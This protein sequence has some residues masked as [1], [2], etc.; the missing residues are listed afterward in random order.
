MTNT[1]IQLQSETAKAF[2][3]EDFKSLLGFKTNHFRSYVEAPHHMLYNENATRG[4][5]PYSIFLHGEIDG[6]PQWGLK[7]PMYVKI[8]I[9]I[10]VLRELR[11]EISFG[12]DD[13]VTSWVAPPDGLLEWDR[14][15]RYSTRTAVNCSYQAK[16]GIKSNNVNFGVGFSYQPNAT[17]DYRI[18]N[19]ITF[20]GEYR[21]LLQLQCE[22][23]FNKPHDF[24]AQVCLLLNNKMANE[25]IT[26]KYIDHEWYAIKAF[27]VRTIYK[28][29][30]YHNRVHDHILGNGGEDDYPELLL[31]PGNINIQQPHR[32]VEATQEEPSQPPV[33]ARPGRYVGNTNTR[34]VHDIENITEACNF[35]R[36]TEEHKDYFDSIAEVEDAINTQGYNGCHWCMS[37]YDT[38]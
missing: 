24:A 23:D 17:V 37:K 29:I 21:R 34:E 9:H 38:G 7:S 20:N 32:Q 3:A 12:P 30:A 8:D 22:Y 10:S 16:S 35:G 5:Q 19:N 25:Y 28:F 1:Q 36:M 13:V 4:S 15:E 26:G 2:H 18:R 27:R 11:E 6:D 33:V 31:L 14:V